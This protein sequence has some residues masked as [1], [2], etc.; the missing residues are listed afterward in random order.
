MLSPDLAGQSSDGIPYPLPWS[1]YRDGYGNLDI[2]GALEQQQLGETLNLKTKQHYVQAY[3]KHFHPLFPI[4]HPQTYQQHRSSPLLSAAV[5][6]VGAQYTDKPFAKSDSRILHQKC[7]ELILKVGPRRTFAQLCTAEF[8]DC[9]EVCRHDQDQWTV[10]SSTS[11]LLSGTA[12]PFQ[13][14]TGTFIF[15]RRL[16]CRLQPSEFVS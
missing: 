8:A 5:M 4:L 10:G 3:W 1:G 15:V 9:T 2:E 12:L 6:A 11:S 14:K 16:S 7:Q 13:S